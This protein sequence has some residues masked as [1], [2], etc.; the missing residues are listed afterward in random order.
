[1]SGNKGGTSWDI[2]AQTSVWLSL[3]PA[4]MDGPQGCYLAEI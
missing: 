1:M 3:L 2:G 4:G